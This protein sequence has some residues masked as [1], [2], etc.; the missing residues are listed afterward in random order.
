MFTTYGINPYDDRLVLKHLDQT[1]LNLKLPRH[2]LAGLK[3]FLVK[4]LQMD[5]II[6][7]FIIMN[8]MIFLSTRLD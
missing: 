6:V 1:T 5:D 7:T 3:F 2:T 8:I 4:L